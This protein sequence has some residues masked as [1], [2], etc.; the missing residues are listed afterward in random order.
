MYI[1]AVSYA[2]CSQEDGMTFF[3]AEM[4]IAMSQL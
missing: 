1:S 3:F 2:M 4:A